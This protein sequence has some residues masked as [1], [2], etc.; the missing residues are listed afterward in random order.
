MFTQLL[1]RLCR[2]PPRPDAPPGDEATTQV[3]R[4]SPK[5]R[6]YRTAL[7][8][9]VAVPVGL[10]ALVPLAVALFADLRSS[11]DREALLMVGLAIAAVALLGFSA[12]YLALRL[13]YAY[14]WYLLTDRSLRVREGIFIVREMT[15]TFA[16]VQNL[17]VDQGPLQRSFGIADVK[18]ETAGGGG[19]AAAKQGTHVRSLHTARL[20]G[21][22]N[23]EAVRDLIRSRLRRH[24]DA[25]L[26]DTDDAEAATG[27][28]ALAEAA[29]AVLAE[30]TA[31]RRT[32]ERATGRPA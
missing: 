24:R 16:N 5:Y 27:T 17:T 4:A 22:E 14:R 12:S 25:G 9:L 7:W 23:P 15:V 30:A 3:F 2:I 13:D 6:S 26:G 8:A 10:L 19:G 28:P 11:S 31:L 18:V 1:D 29:A 20:S 32:M 21:L